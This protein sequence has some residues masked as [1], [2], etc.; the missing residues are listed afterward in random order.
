MLC[1]ITQ[2][3]QVATMRNIRRYS[4]LCELKTF[5]ERYEY[6]KLNGVVGSE[7]FG[8]D[9]FLNQKF[10]KSPEW[11]KVRDQV[12]IRDNGCDL[13]MEG[14]DI[15]KKVII[16]HMNPIL[17]KDIEYA[18]EYLLDPEY[19]ICVSHETHN[20]IHYGDENQLVKGPVIRTPNDTCPWKT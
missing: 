9:R 2:A 8:F 6:L 15:Y 17:Q 12:I 1:V 5:E 20:A 4:E 7:T 19:L 13:G 16:H 3:E 18:T 11:K 14:H 10:Y